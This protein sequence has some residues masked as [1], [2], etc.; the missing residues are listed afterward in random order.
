MS[1]IVMHPDLQD[2][3]KKQT[4]HQDG[5]SKQNIALRLLKQNQMKKRKKPE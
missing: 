1:E 2:G 3:K 5:K 4:L